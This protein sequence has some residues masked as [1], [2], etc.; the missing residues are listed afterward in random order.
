[1]FLNCGARAAEKL[2]NR[3]VAPPQFD[4]DQQC[5]PHILRSI[6]KNKYSFG[7]EKKKKC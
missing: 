6:N 1:M 3:F 7:K 2:F 4:I 5:K